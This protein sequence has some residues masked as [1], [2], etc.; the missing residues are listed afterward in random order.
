ML[1][2]ASIQH[3]FSQFK[4]ANVVSTESLLPFAA[5]QWDNMK[6]AVPKLKFII[7]V[8]DYMSRQGY[9][10]D[11]LRIAEALKRSQLHPDASAGLHL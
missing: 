7:T 9:V 10:G 11:F 4:T 5:G 6:L 3:A 2:S 1:D 8:E